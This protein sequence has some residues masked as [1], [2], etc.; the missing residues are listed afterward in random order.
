MLRYIDHAKA[1]GILLMIIGHFWSVDPAIRGFIY[2]FHMPLFFIIAGFLYRRV[3]FRERAR[4]DWRALLLPYLLV[5]GCCMVIRLAVPAFTESGYELGKHFIAQLGAVVIGES[6]P[7]FGLEPVCGPSWFILAIAL[8]HAMSYLLP[9]KNKD[10]R[11]Y[12]WVGLAES[13]V[14]VAIVWCFNKYGVQIPGPTDAV[15]MA[16]PFF[17]FGSLLRQWD[18]QRLRS[19]YCVLS[20]ALCAVLT[21]WMNRMN[22]PVD[23]NTLSYGKDMAVYYACSVTGSMAVLFFSLLVERMN[24]RQGDAFAHTIS[25]GTIV[26]VGFHRFGIAICEYLGV[27]TTL[28]SLV[29][30]V[31]ILFAF[32]PLILFLARYAPAFVGYRQ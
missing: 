23:I 26:V 6:M 32:Y 21:F 15:L 3:T 4:K 1:I 31:L 7:I 8:L 24:F 30:S 12:V 19:G 14:C 22:G 13:A 18:L 20:L 16:F 17:W 29:A 28:P 25:V 11:R 2:S 10:L 27:S 5:N 9:D